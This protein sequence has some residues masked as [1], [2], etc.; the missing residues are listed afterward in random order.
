M[1]GVSG[2]PGTKPSQVKQP[3]ATKNAQND[4]DAMLAEFDAPAASAPPPASEDVSA[5][6]NE[7]AGEAPQAPGPDQFAPQPGFVQANIEQFNPQNL[8]DRLQAGLAANDV[9]KTN[10]LKKKYGDQ[11]VAEKDGVIYYRRSPK[12]KL[13]PLDPSTFEL[14]ADLIPDFAR[15]IVTESAM[16]PGELGGAALAALPSVGAGAPAGAAAGRVA[17]IPFANKVA[18]TVS[19]Y[20]G[21]PQDENRNLYGENAMGMAF[22]TAVPVVGG[23]LAQ[24][25]AKRIPGT[26]AYKAA[27][28]AAQSESVALS[29][30]SE[31]VVQALN[32]LEKEGQH[33]DIMSHQVHNT[34]PQLEEIAQKVDT[35]G[36]F[37]KKQ[38]EVAEGY[39]DILEKNLEEIARLDG[40]MQ[41]KG[42]LAEKL[43]NAVDSLDS[44]EGK[45]IGEY[46][47]KAMLN[48]KN[49]KQQLPPQTS[50]LATQMMQELGFQPKSVQL[51]SVTRPGSFHGVEQRGGLEVG[52]TINR[53]KWLPPKNLQPVIGRLGLDEG[54]ARAMV[55]VLGEYSELISRGNSARLS[56]VERMIS[57]MG[58]M[59]QRMRG[60]Q[61]GAMLGKLTGDLRQFRRQV[62]GNALDTDIDRKLFNQKMDNFGMIRSNTEQLQNVLRADVTTKTLIN[63]FFRGKEN[64]ANV[65]SIK[66]LVGEDSTEWAGLK[67][68]F[69]DNLML[70]HADSASPTGYNSKAFLN[71]LQKNY[72]DDFMREVINSGKGPNLN[73]IKN[74]LTVGQRI[75]STQRALKVNPANER[76]AAAGAEVLFGAVT[77]NRYRVGNGVR[78]VLGITG[79]KESALMELFNRYGYEKY[80]SGYKGKDK[81]Q[82]ANS[83]EI[84]LNQYNS[85]RAGAK[86]VR[87]LMDVGKRA[88]RADVRENYVER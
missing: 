32:Q 87:G 22:E 9:E 58:P 17:S 41:G 19:E 54:Q 83:I 82:L 60:T 43:T 88:V 44:A 10:L 63:S 18:N 66:K 67:E 85:E 74:L 30:G 81:S 75:E 72:G 61:G 55:N 36:A 6:I 50:E 15:E 56:D 26:M 45:A 77:N 78:K 70:K 25:V 52:N 79:D 42:A 5:L 1:A 53:V 13:R 37:L 7:A 34:S 57:R 51:K 62:I 33:L 3:V 2:Q 20:A 11:N 38:Q 39:S 23:K 65:R 12:E 29:K 86:T 21:V 4:V 48:L 24:V 47:K 40:S 8:V 49:Q 64:L 14:V 31:E 35:S 46:R 28:E 73:T 80:L 27:R 16:L 69:I 76:I 68:A 84:L 71:D 59:T